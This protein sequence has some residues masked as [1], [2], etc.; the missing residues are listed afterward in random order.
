MLILQWDNILTTSRSHSLALINANTEG[1]VINVAGFIKAA[2]VKK[3]E[4]RHIFQTLDR[5]IRKL[6]SV[7]SDTQHWDRVLRM[8][9]DKFDE[10]DR[11]LIAHERL[12]RLFVPETVAHCIGFL[13]ATKD[14]IN[15]QLPN[16]AQGEEPKAA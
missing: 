5:R 14:A 9:G 12:P 15:A 8:I 1:V 13:T 6:S 3:S 4:L 16:T 10:I 11:Q 7:P 2:S